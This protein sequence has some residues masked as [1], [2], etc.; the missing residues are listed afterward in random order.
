M[1]FSLAV[2]RKLCQ[3]F[4]EH[5]VLFM[6]DFRYSYN[7]DYLRVCGKDTF[8]AKQIQKTAYLRGQNIDNYLATLLLAC[9]CIALIRQKFSVIKQ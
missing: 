2:N 1:F 3:G 9:A 4:M 5:Q 8:L 7:Q 6:I